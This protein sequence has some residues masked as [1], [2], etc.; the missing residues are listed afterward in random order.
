MTTILGTEDFD[1]TEVDPSTV[2]LES[3]AVKA[4]GKSDKLLAHIEDANGDGFADL[5]VQMEDGDG[6]FEVGDTIATVSGNLL[7]E[8]GT[9]PIEGSDSICIA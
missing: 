9:T 6:V 5:V 1:A 8:F 2:V 4:V 3:L 7:P